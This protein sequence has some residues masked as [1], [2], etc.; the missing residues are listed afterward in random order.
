LNFTQW[1]NQKFEEKDRVLS[2]GLLEKN[3]KIGLPFKISNS[4]IAKKIV[5]FFKV[6]NKTSVFNSTLKLLT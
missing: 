6:I 5:F 3:I 2:L 4:F 1:D